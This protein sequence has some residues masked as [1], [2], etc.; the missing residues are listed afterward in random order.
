MMMLL[1]AP[2]RMVVIQP[3]TTGFK[4]AHDAEPSMGSLKGF[5]EDV[6]VAREFRGDVGPEGRRIGCR[7]T[8]GGVVDLMEIDDDVQ[9]LAGG[10]VDRRLENLADIVGCGHWGGGGAACTRAAANRV[11]QG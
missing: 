11:G 4:V 6:A 8:C 5:V 9:V 3:C 10:V 7:S 2:A 1:G